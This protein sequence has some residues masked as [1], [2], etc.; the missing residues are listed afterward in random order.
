VLLGPEVKFAMNF[1]SGAI[2][3]GQLLDDG[4]HCCR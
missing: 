3:A 4:R 2:D 1:L